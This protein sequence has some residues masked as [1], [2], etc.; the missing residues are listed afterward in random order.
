VSQILNQKSNVTPTS[1]VVTTI[2][3]GTKNDN[4]ENIFISDLEQFLRIPSLK[5]INKEVEDK[6]L[7]PEEIEQQIRLKHAD[8]KDLFRKL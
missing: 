5:N 1:N 3:Q 4:T 8:L 6:I 2:N 7:S